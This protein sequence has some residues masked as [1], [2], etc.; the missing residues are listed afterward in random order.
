MFK[1]VYL[2]NVQKYIWVFLLDLRQ[3][4]VSCEQNNRNLQSKYAELSTNLSI[5]GK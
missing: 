5:S 3:H 4:V 2:L 1:E